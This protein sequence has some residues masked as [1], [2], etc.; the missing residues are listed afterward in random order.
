MD[1]TSSP[2]TTTLGALL[3]ECVEHLVQSE[4]Q[5][6][7][8]KAEWLLADTAGIPRL[9]FPLYRARAVDEA[10]RN[11]MRERTQRLADGEPLQYVLGTA[12]FM[13]LLFRVDRRVLIPRPETE[14]LVEWTLAEIARHPALQPRVADIGTGS[15]CIAVTL[16]ARLPEARITAVDLSEDE[17]AIARQNAAELAP[18]AS[19]TWTQGDGLYGF[20]KQ[21]LDVVVSNP[22]YV[23]E[24]AWR[25]L[26]R[27][28]RDFEPRSALTTGEDGFAILHR[29]LA[30]APRVLAPRG[31]ILLECGE[32]QAEAL[33]IRAEQEGLVDVQVHRDLAGRRRGIR[34]RQADHPA[35]AD[36]S[37]P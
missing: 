16:A 22:P 18:G 7:S 30:E 11:R 29:L 3:D 9:E 14:C 10:T 35:R 25:A 4:R 26:D 37:R 36:G 1:M 32:E 5:D 33:R 31:S 12:D 24:G 21:S 8:L 23:P 6:A 15:G 28:V 27:E 13:G 2:G 17:L 19:I 34:A 20:D